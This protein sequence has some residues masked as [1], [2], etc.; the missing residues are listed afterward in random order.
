MSYNP[1]YEDG[2][3]KAECDLCGKLFKASRLRK[4]WDGYKV[5]PSDWEIR[6]PQDFVK[7]KADIQVPKWTRPEM[8]NTF[9]TIPGYDDW[10]NPWGITWG[11]TW[12][13]TWGYS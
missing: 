10:L 7:A 12:A 3:W 11:L 2:D 1:R 13:R 5:C 4:R 9:I 8:E 6:Q